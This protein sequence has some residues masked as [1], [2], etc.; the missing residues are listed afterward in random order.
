ML[1]LDGVR[2][3]FVRQASLTLTSSLA[4]TA[5]R[6]KIQAIREPDILFFADTHHVHLHLH[7]RDALARPRRHLSCDRN[8]VERVQG[9]LASR[10][11]GRSRS[12][13]RS[14]RVDGAARR[15]WFHPGQSV[16][17]AGLVW[18]GLVSCLA[19]GLGATQDAA[20]KGSLARDTTDP[21]N[22]WQ[23]LVIARASSFV[24]LLRISKRRVLHLEVDEVRP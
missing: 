6:V 20:T 3:V 12:Q 16:H 23:M 7:T 4:R 24:L 22:P 10:A 14:G 9:A 13:A 18:S 21:E 8:A 5:D 19:D 17:V 15:R 11:V 1:L 2:L